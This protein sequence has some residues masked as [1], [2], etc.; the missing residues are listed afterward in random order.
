MASEND[1]VIPRK[2]VRSTFRLVWVA[3]D[4]LQVDHLVVARDED[5][6]R[7]ISAGELRS[8]VGDRF[9]SWRLRTAC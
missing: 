6:A 7:R 1:A 4:E 5:E 2:P 3:P 8:A 9:A